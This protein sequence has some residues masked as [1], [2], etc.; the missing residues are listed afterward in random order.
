VTDQVR[1][2]DDDIERQLARGWQLLELRRPAEAADFV[3][4]LVGRAPE[5]PRVWRCLA[6]ALLADGRLDDAIQ[7]AQLTIALD[8]D[9]ADGYLTAARGLDRAGRRPEA[10]AMTRRG[11][12]V[13]PDRW[14]S[15]A[16]HGLV[17]CNGLGPGKVSLSRNEVAE[18][19]AAGARGVQLAPDNPDAFNALGLIQTQAGKLSEAE[20]SFRRALA[21]N[22]QH[23]AA[24]N[25]LA[26]LATRKKLPSPD[27]LADAAAG[28]STA[29]VIDPS[30]PVSRDN[31]ERTLLAA[32][33]VTSALILVAVFS[34]GRLASDSDEIV[35][36]IIPVLALALPAWFGVRLWHRLTPPLRAR[37]VYLTTR[38]DL[39]IGCLL[40]SM[41]V[42]C[43]ILAAAAPHGPRQILGALAAVMAVAGRLAVA[44]HT[45]RRLGKRREFAS[46][47]LLWFLVVAGIAFTVL[48]L[49]TI[50]AGGG[51]ISLVLACTCAVG[52]AWL[53][54]VI[55]RRR[56]T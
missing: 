12:T 34:V 9:S 43:M 37:L 33:T 56:A 48:L 27:R 23:H 41:A 4:G 19:L 29:T 49:A 26:R 50:S 55:R 40:L 28:F 10:L 5:D 20:Q 2:T 54:V 53:L 25:N 38:S 16:V 17:L 30:S 36:R 44:R 8:P 46:T 32:L 45:D 14:D 6:A 24:H 21:L 31:L 13:A 35:P 15:H 18:S 42:A 47:S 7:A 51:G 22:P 52:T 11:L 39:R 1:A 3:G